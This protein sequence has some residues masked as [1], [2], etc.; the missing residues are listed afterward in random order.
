MFAAEERGAISPTLARPTPV[1]RA[2]PCC[3]RR[4]GPGGFRPAFGCWPIRHALF[5]LLLAA[6][7][8]VQPAEVRRHLLVG[9]QVA[10]LVTLDED[11]VVVLPFADEGHDHE[12]ALRRP[13]VEG[14][15]SAS[16]MQGGVART[17]HAL[18]VNKAAAARRGSGLAA[19]ALPRVPR[20]AAAVRPSGPARVGRLRWPWR[21][22]T[23]GRG[24]APACRAAPGASAGRAQDLGKAGLGEGGRVEQHGEASGGRR[25]QAAQAPRFEVRLARGRR[26]ESK[27]CGMV[28]L[29]PGST[30]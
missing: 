10:S 6:Y 14:G 21:L 11:V 3:G 27:G 25:H 26:R 9:A 16:L 13:D 12:L 2:A 29:L 5:A 30:V 23:S 15:L 17:G 20:G 19:R 28:R 8:A 7:G 4:R 22:R 24:S 1:G 18:P